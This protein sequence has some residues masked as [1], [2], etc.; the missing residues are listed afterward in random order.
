MNNISKIGDNNGY[1]E[2][3]DTFPLRITPWDLFMA[4]ALVRASSGIDAVA[5]IAEQAD[6]AMEE[7]EK[8]NPSFL[9]IKAGD[10]K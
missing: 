7:R 5:K 8:R 6:M 1:L 4:A 3:I 9:E 10:T 2:L